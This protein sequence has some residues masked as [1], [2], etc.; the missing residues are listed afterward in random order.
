MLQRASGVEESARA[1]HETGS[2]GYVLCAI[3]PVGELGE[4]DCGC[5]SLYVREREGGER[6]RERSRV[7]Q[8]LTRAVPR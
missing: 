2:S 3:C 1:E 8:N 4:V 6:G 5:A 7:E